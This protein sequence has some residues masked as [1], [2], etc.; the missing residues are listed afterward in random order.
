MHAED[1]PLLATARVGAIQIALAT[2]HGL[3]DLVVIVLAREETPETV[4]LVHD[5]TDR[6]IAS[7]GDQH[8]C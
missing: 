2:Q 3:P 7:V 4:Y 6:Y 5:Q 1:W 8:P